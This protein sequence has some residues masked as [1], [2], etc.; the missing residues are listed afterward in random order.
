MDKIYEQY[1]D[2]DFSNAKPA[3]EI[4]ALQKLRQAYADSQS[5]SKISEVS[6]SNYSFLDADIVDWVSRRP[7]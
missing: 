4:P 7:R 6:A 1:K 3:S 2:H 5:T